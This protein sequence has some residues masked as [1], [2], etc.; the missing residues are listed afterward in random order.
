MRVPTRVPNFVRRVTDPLLEGVRV[1]VLSGVNRG[2]WWSLVSAGAGYGSGRR[3]SAQMELFAELVRPGDVVWDVGA[4]HG[5]VTL[6]AAR[7]VGPAGAVHA[8]EPSARNRALLRRHVRWNRL[9]NVTVHPF[10]LSDYDGEASFGGSGTSKTYA[11][12]RGSETVPVRTAATLVTQGICPPPTF[13][14]LDVEGAEADALVGALGVLPRSARLLIAVHGREADQRSSQLLQCLGFELVA[15][16]LLEECRRGEWRSDP[17]L[18][19]IGPECETREAD[20]ALLRRAG[21]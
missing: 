21:F 2:Q 13:M 6:C 14:K 16:R 20:L 19:C 12:G 10:A 15:S 11:F 7:R 3:A 17:D 8:F 9:G 4:H 5:F 1:P 18:F